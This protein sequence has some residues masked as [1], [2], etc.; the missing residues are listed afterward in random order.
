MWLVSLFEGA[1]HICDIQ[2]IYK[3]QT[4]E[5]HLLHVIDRMYCVKLKTDLFSLCVGG[6]MTSQKLMFI[7]QQWCPLWHRLREHITRPVLGKYWK[8]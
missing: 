4:G 8:L 2:N 6:N 1:G 5:L 7:M 3:N